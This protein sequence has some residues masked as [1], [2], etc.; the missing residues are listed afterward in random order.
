MTSGKQIHQPLLGM[1]YWSST[2]NSDTLH[3]LVAVQG[4]SLQAGILR[5]AL[6]DRNQKL[7]L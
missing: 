3:F 1:Y 4:I 5:S 2:D 6:S 7:F